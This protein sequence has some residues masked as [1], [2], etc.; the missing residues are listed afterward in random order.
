MSILTSDFFWGIVIG[1]LLSL[2]GSYALA[3][4]NFS[5][6]QKNQKKVIRLFC[7]DVIQNIKNIVS[8]MDATRDRTKAIHHDF[9]SLLDVEI[10][11]YG[12]NREHLIHLPPDERENVRKL[13]NN[14]AIKKAEISQGLESFY[15]ASRLADQVQ[16]AGRGPEAGRIRSDA[17]D[18]LQIAQTAAD[19]LVQIMNT[20]TS[21]INLLG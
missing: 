10:G 14:I 20:A 12:R 17:N 1:L 2:I 6:M 9:L 5:I 21:Q 11:V 19:K 18:H 7:A 8:E 4:F 16:A 13:I 15:E 3:K